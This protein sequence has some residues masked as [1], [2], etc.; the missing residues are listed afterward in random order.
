MAGIMVPNFNDVPNEIPLI[1]AGLR[2]FMVKA[3]P[4]VE[5]DRNDENHQQ[6]SLQLS[7]ADDTEE[8]G[9]VFFDN[10]RITDGR[11]AVKAKRFLLSIGLKPNADGTVNWASAVGMIGVAIVKHKTVTKDGIKTYANVADYVIPGE[12]GY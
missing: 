12:P 7:I 1:A 9:R 6:L 8:K 5:Q 4:K 10:P 3:E 11:G 2:K